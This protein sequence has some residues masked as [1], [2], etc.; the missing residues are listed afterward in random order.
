[1][2][3]LANKISMARP[4]S[5]IPEVYNLK[6]RLQGPTKMS[7]APA[8]SGRVLGGQVLASVDRHDE[9]VLVE[10]V[11]HGAVQRPQHLVLVVL[12]ENESLLGP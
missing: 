10:A 12:R 5:P 11:P 8:L 6:N 1:M 9:R 4:L 7:S 2:T 3:R